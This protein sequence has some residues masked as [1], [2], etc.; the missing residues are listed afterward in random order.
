M[1]ESGDGSLLTISQ[2]ARLLGVH[3]GTLRRW[4]KMGLLSAIRPRLDG[5]RLYRPDAVAAY[6][7]NRR[8]PATLIERVTYAALLEEISRAVSSSLDLPAIYRAIYDGV[9]AAMDVDGFFLALYDE[10]TNSLD[11]QLLI[12]G[13]EDRSL[14]TTVA[15]G[16]SLAEVLRTRR[17]L[18]TG[19]R[20]G[21]RGQVNERIASLILVPLF[22]GTELLAVFSIQSTEPAAYTTAQVELL[23][24]VA[25]RVTPAIR[26]A[27]LYA[28]ARE[29]EVRYRAL[30]EQAADA[31]FV[32]DQ[33]GHYIE[34]NEAA[35]A[36]FGFSREELLARTTD[37]LQNG[38]MQSPEGE[39]LRER[40]A[41]GPVRVEMRMQRKDG[42]QIPVELRITRIHVGGQVLFQAICRDMT[43]RIALEAVREREHQ[44][45]LASVR[46][47]AATVDA[48]DAY[49]HSHSQQVAFYCRR[50][51]QELGLPDEEVETIELAGLLHDIGKI[52]VPDYI[53]QKPGRLN[54]DEW[55]IMRAHS[56]KGAD[57][58]S[59][60]NSA[61]LAAIVPMV[62][63]HHERWAGGGY[64]DGLEGD[65]IPL[66]AAVIAL[67]DAFDTITTTRPYK[68]AS[69]LH[70][71]CVE[72]RRSRGRHFKPEIADAF[73]RIIERDRAAGAEYL[74]AITRM[75]EPSA[76]AV[77]RLAAM[78]AEPL[79]PLGPE[80][81]TYQEQQRLA[82]HMQSLY[83]ISRGFPH[84]TGEAE[85]VAAAA[86]LAQDHFG[87]ESV[88]LLEVRDAEQSQGAGG[89][90]AAPHVGARWGWH[91]AG[92]FEPWTTPDTAIY[93]LLRELM[94]AEQPVAVADIPSVTGAAGRAFVLRQ[95]WRSGIFIPLRAG[96]KTLGALGLAYH[97]G[98]H[99]FTAD[100]LELA[101]TLGAAAARA[102]AGV[103]LQAAEQQLRHQISELERSNQALARRSRD[104]TVLYETARSLIEILDVEALCRRIVQ[105]LGASFSHSL[106]SVALIEGTLLQFRAWYGYEGVT[107][108]PAIPLTHGVVGRVVR[109]G[110]PALVP[111]VRTDP[112]YI[113]VHPALR[114]EICVPLVGRDG[115]LGVV[116]IESDSPEPLDEE[117]L[118]L[119]LTLTPQIVIALENARLYTAAQ[120]QATRLGLINRVAHAMTGLLAGDAATLLDHVARLFQH[121]LGYANISIMLIDPLTHEL[122]CHASAGEY[123]S[124]ISV[125]SRLPQG[126]GLTGWVA[127]HGTTLVANDV[128]TEPRFY[129]AAPEETP[130]AE[131]VAP[132]IHQGRIIGVLDVESCTPH[133]FS[134]GDVQ[135]LET[136]ADQL[137]VAIEH[138]DIAQ[139]LHGG[140]HR[141]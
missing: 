100:D 133:S 4:D 94:A 18:R 37:A 5:P 78:P 41:A 132:L 2:A 141:P 76:S 101:D 87:A 32:T 10:R 65:A 21:L 140:G 109:T 27:R 131:L 63:S 98:Y 112:D 84:V 114:S 123:V 67:A 31:V 117:D 110:Q 26:N 36:L 29:E 70:E 42:S 19:R 40:L 28:R 128:A 66:G 23:E 52:A 20:G 116:N 34:I 111:D 121:E 14:P 58:L 3:V 15:I 8:Q 38:F 17:A 13:G 113:G 115:V 74:E 49:T 92:D 61:A 25:A 48:R 46:S 54:A 68:A 125:G 134:P 85:L 93:P 45:Y 120:Q 135:M 24:R 107:V 137:A 119:L 102:F 43:P 12:D 130:G 99:S 56:A 35:A 73:L 95:G 11:T 89:A 47:L 79:R 97:S 59:A 122:V 104:L 57:I 77:P 55:A 44:L 16:D 60:G 124:C 103:Q 50:I 90:H 64:P 105:V 69:T 9:R 86:R 7:N 108:I 106:I 1:Q 22:Q 96:G 127:T 75:A 62:R 51:A 81:L 83:E 80:S 39:N 138:A 91:A 129:Q 88:Y 136:L 126:L 72:I 33:R 71:A 30:L 139:T 118:H 53:L 6:L 82:A